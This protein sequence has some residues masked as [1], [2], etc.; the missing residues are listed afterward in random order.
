MFK[1]YMCSNIVKFLTP[2]LWQLT[3]IKYH[4]NFATDGAK[5]IAGSTVVL[6]S[7]PTGIYSILFCDIGKEEGSITFNIGKVHFNTRMEPTDDNKTLERG[8]ITLCALAPYLEMCQQTLHPYQLI[9]GGGLPKA[10]HLSSRL[11][12]FP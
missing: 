3:C 4:D 10:G 11:T 12:S 5:A 2:I 9:V 7:I 1:Q 8:S 6:Y